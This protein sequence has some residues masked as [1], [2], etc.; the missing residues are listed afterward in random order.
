MRSE[1]SRLLQSRLIVKIQTYS[2]EIQRIKENLYRTQ[3]ENT[4]K[5]EKIYWFKE[6]L[7]LLNLSAKDLQTLKR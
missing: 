7:N 6:R 3:N 1:D 5:R 4:T 2:D